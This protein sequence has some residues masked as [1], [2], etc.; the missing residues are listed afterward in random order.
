MPPL[1][2]IYTTVALLSN[3]ILT[4]WPWRELV[5]GAKVNRTALSSKTLMCNVL[6]CADQRP[7]KR[8]TAHGPSFQWPP[9]PSIDMP[10]VTIRMGNGGEKGQPWERL[11]TSP[12]HR[13]ARR[14]DA[15]VMTPCLNP[16]ALVHEYFRNH[17]IGHIQSWAHLTTLIVDAIRPR[18]WSHWTAGLYLPAYKKAHTQLVSAVNIAGGRKTNPRSRIRSRLFL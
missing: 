9:Q 1:W 6:F 15:G 16:W 17:W 4:G 12:H 7:W 13:S 8:A 2:L 5:S 10:V 18:R 3:S 11:F 14:S